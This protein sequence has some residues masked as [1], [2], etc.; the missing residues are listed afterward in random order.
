MPGQAKDPT[1]GVNIAEVG[2]T[3]SKW[4]EIKTAVIHKTPNLIYIY[5]QSKRRRRRRLV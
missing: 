4:R 5:M 3:G 2:I 1:R